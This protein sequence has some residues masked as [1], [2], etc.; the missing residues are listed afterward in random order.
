ME[1]C[2]L[3]IL[4]SRP[5]HKVLR[6]ADCLLCRADRSGKTFNEIPPLIFLVTGYFFSKKNL[7]ESLG[8]YLGRRPLKK[9]QG[10]AKVWFYFLLR[11]ESLTTQQ[12][13]L[14]VRHTCQAGWSFVFLKQNHIWKFF[15][16]ITK[17]CGSEPAFWSGKNVDQRI[18]DTPGIT[19]LLTPRVLIDGLD[20]H[21]DVGSSHPLAVEGKKGWTV[22]PWKRYVSWVQCVVT[23]HGSSLWKGKKT[24]WKDFWVR[25]DLKVHT[26]GVSVV[27]KIAWPSS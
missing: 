24:F 8:V 21:L 14:I 2:P 25:K 26:S 20:W 5:L 7:F 6:F 12:P 4:E 15:F 10:R 27:K 22:R 23:Q 18:K 3:T 13:C 17:V 1:V 16:Q 9:Y 11:F 19:G